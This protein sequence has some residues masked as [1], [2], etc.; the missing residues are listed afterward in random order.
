MILAIDI[1][2]TKTL[3]G[4]FGKDGKLQKSYKFETPADYPDFVRMLQEE[5]PKFVGDT[6]ITDCVSAVPGKLDR[7]NGVCIA[8]GNRPWTNIPIGQDLSTIVGVSVRI[9][10]DSKLAGLSE[11]L[12]LPE[13]RKALYITVSTG[14]GSAFVVDGRLDPNTIDAEVGHMMLEH[15]GKLQTWEHFASGKAIFEKFGKKASDITDESAWYIIARN[16]AIGLIDV[17]ATMTPDVVIMGGG[18][19]SHLPKFQA[20]LEEEL[21][22]YQTSVVDIPPIKQAQRPE[23][24]VIYGCYALTQQA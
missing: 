19:G 16:I 7:E 3:L 24:A 13:Y 12:L 18:V 22:L 17:I 23:E 14:I 20:R 6:H 9:E 4:L 1:G 11:A 10:N 5:I 8:L 2:G 15:M 21:K